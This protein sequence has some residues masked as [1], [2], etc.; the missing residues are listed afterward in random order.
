MLMHDV[1]QSI[2][3]LSQVELSTSV[4]ESL[5]FIHE[6]DENHFGKRQNKISITESVTKT[7]MS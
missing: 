6:V 5:P 1:T 4:L 3:T 2:T 7:H